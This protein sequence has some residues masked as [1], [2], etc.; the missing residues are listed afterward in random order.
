M[1]NSVVVIRNQEMQVK[2]FKGERV[3]SFKEIDQ[4]HER[5]EGVSRK[6]FFNNKER[7]IDGEDYF[8]VKPSDV[9]NFPI[10]LNNAGT[11]LLTESGYLMLVKSFTDDLAWQVQRQLV[12]TYFRAKEMAKQSELETKL[13]RGQ[14]MLLNAKARQAKL[15]VQ[16]AENFKEQ[17][18]GDSIQLLLGGAAELLLGRPLLPKPK[19]SATYTAGEIGEEAGVSANK[20]GRMAN[21]HGLKTS[22]YGI[23]VLDKSRY[24][25]KQV[26]SFV[27]NEKGREKLLELFALSE[28]KN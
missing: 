1:N 11:I 21:Q 27:Y 13:S 10:Q 2:E 7:F 17:I 23:S 6:N 22:E 16:M 20:I 3:V 5:V 28:A 25:S 24:S 14:A 19:I 26:S 4:I 15:M 9:N 18:S 12:S 8:V